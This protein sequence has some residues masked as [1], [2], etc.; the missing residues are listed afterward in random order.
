MRQNQEVLVK[1]AN[2]EGKIGSFGQTVA[3]LDSA[4]AGAGVWKKLVKQI[5][6]FCQN[7]NNLWLS[8]LNNEGD[9]V[10]VEGY[11]LTRNSLTDFAYSINDAVLQSMLYEELRERSAY[12]Y[13]L[14]FKIS[15]QK[16]QNE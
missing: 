4:A 16:Y 2:L 1:I 10:N 11:S 3:I 8:K 5:S 6:G 14:N 12:R 9:Q 15:N 7:S 13:N